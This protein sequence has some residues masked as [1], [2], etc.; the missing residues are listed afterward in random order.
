MR[1][2]FAISIVWTLSVSEVVTADDVI[3]IGSRRELL[4]DNFLIKR[5]K[6]DADLKLHHPIPREV[7]FTADRP[8]EGNLMF[9]VTVFRDGDIYRMYYRGWDYD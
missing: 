5:L 7:V 6:G 2:S 9:H 3:E 1:I 4:V 8:W